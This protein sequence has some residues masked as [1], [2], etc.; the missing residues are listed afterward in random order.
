MQHRIQLS[1]QLMIAAKAAQKAKVN[2]KPIVAGIRIKPL[3]T[4][5]PEKSMHTVDQHGNIIHTLSKEEFA[6]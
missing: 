6:A 4:A 2:F 5:V 1:T 3:T